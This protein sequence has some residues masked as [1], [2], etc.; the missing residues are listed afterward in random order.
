M[1]R[2][3]SIKILNTQ[4]ITQLSKAEVFCH[5]QPLPSHPSLIFDDKPRAYPSG[6]LTGLLL[7]IPVYV[8]AYIHMSPISH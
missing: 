4:L 2:T 1:R 3:S 7:A 8:K 5:C 6:A